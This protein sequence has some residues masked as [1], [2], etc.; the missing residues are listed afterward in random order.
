MKVMVTSSRP[1]AASA[2]G[3]WIR[4]PR[5]GVGAGGGR[6]DDRDKGEDREQGGAKRTDE[7]GHYAVVPSGKRIAVS[8]RNDAS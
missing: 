3:R 1:A 4:F 2:P 7:G 6:E 8:R 5:L